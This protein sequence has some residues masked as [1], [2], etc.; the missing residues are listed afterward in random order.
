MR[1]LTRGAIDNTGGDD[2]ILLAT[3]V[4]I[5]FRDMWR[6]LN[7]HPEYNSANGYAK[8]FWSGDLHSVYVRIKSHDGLRE[9]RTP[10]AIP[11]N[12]VGGAR[13]TSLCGQIMRMLLDG[14]DLARSNFYDE[15]AF[16]RLSNNQDERDQYFP[17]DTPGFRFQLVS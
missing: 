6:L 1:Q 10:S 13:H 9:V 7:G 12:H 4:A 8:L 17:L 5:E 14:R 3:E 16:S 15:Y 11:G 2:P